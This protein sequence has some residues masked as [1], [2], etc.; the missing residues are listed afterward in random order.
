MRK[1]QTE[2]QRGRVRHWNGS[3]GFIQAA[4]DNSLYVSAENVIPGDIPQM[5]PGACVSFTPGVI[6][7]G[8]YAGQRCAVAV[9][10]VEVR[11][12]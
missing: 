8:H 7:F 10:I 6:D 9:E 3:F 5:R 11:S 2:R 12:E 4:D 1:P